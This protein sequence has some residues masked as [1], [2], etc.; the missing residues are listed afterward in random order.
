MLGFHS[1]MLLV[2]IGKCCRHRKS[3]STISFRLELQLPF[4]YNEQYNKKKN[5]Q[6]IIQ[7]R[8]FNPY[9]KLVG[10]IE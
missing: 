2:Q 7:A 3:L 5:P 1:D 8:K 9:A 6:K 4:E 10:S